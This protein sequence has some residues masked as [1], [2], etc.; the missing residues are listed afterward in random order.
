MT[1]ILQKHCMQSQKE[2]Q[3][4]HHPQSYSLLSR[5]VSHESFLHTYQTGFD[6]WD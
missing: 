1:V 2:R 4:C 6:V 5:Y 3:F